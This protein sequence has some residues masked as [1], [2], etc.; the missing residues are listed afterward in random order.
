MGLDLHIHDKHLLIVDDNPTNIMLM[1]ALLEEDG[2]EN[3]H[4]ASCAIEAYSILEETSI[5]IILM[6]IMM[7]EID[8]LE[9]TQAIKSNKK[10]SNIP[11]VM[12]TATDDDSL[13]KKSFEY[14]AID[15]VRKPVNQIELLARLKTILISQEKDT[16]LMQHSR[17]DAMEEIIGM[18]AHQWRQPLGIISAI[19]GTLLTQR[20]LDILEDNELDAS[21]EKIAD[22]T[23]TL[24]G[25]IT[26][27][28]EF[29]KADSPP[30]ISSPNEAVYELER[31]MSE[32]LK[33]HKITLELELGEIPTVS[34]VQ[35]LLVQVLTNIVSNAKEAFERNEIHNPKITIRSFVQKQKTIIVV[36]DN[37]GG[38][39]ADMLKNIFEPYFTTKQERN[40]KGLGLFISKSILTQQFNG[41][42][43]ASSKGDKSEFLISF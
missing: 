5:N 1:Q 32:T 37:A 30:T 12:V 19:I 31:L 39:E 20:E 14:G 38:I 13:L 22:H 40:G 41:N 18:L 25:M 6:D 10:Y 9:A 29:F 15:F 4:S 27:F 17:F 34:Y 2:Y 8:G 16:L 21:L 26:T 35:N 11:I 3:I 28:R 33:Q 43:L 36:E 24:S 23:N 7:P 42:I